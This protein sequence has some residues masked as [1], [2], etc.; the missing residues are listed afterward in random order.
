MDAIYIENKNFDLVKYLLQCSM[1]PSFSGGFY[2]TFYKTI[3][4][5]YFNK[6]FEDI[7]KYRSVNSSKKD[8]IFHSDTNNYAYCF[9]G[10]FPSSIRQDY[11]STIFEVS[12]CF[13]F[14]EKIDNFK[15]KKEYKQ[16]NLEF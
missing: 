3:G 2:V 14:F 11:K 12:F 5:D 6:W 13:D 4:W 10:V 16:M 1:N 8:M 15:I 7:G 9:C